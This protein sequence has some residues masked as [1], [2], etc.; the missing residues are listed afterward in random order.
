MKPDIVKIERLIDLNEVVEVTEEEK[1]FFEERT[2]IGRFYKDTI[3]YLVFSS[4][5]V[6]Y[7]TKLSK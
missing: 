6:L 2:Y 7:R 3:C 1:D 5:K 4:N